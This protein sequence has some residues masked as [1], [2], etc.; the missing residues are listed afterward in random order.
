MS[1]GVHGSTRASQAGL[2]PEGRN[3]E[4]YEL[5]NITSQIRHL[6]ASPSF[7][8][9]ELAAQASGSNLSAPRTRLAKERA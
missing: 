8:F 1:N 3:C 5:S 7:G 4:V 9:Y 2:V 6:R